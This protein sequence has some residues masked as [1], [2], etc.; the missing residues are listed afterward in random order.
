M[1]CQ[2]VAA[3]VFQQAARNSRPKVFDYTIAVKMAITA[4]RSSKLCKIILFNLRPFMPKIRSAK[5]GE[6]TWI[7]LFLQLAAVCT[8][9]CGIL[10]AIINPALNAAGLITLLNF[11]G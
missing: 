1:P 10:A 9:E 11:T 2:S 3:Y 8:A 6:N 5:T 7:F 4:A